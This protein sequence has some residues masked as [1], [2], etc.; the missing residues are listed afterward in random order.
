MVLGGFPLA[1]SLAEA[2]FAG[3]RLWGSCTGQPLGCSSSEL[4]PLAFGLWSE[5]CA[6][7]NIA[8]VVALGLLV[9]KDM[10]L[11]P[12]LTVHVDT[13]LG[14]LNL[15]RVAVLARETLPELGEAYCGC[16]DL[17]I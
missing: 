6:E 13:T 10:P 11:A 14:P 3:V 2:A 17:F 15:Q 12:C 5:G 9:L 1:L 7:R 16:G 4:D 8:W